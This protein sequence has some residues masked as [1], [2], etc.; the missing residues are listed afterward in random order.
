MLVE[1][2]N[3]QVRKPTLKQ[4][5]LVKRSVEIQAL[6]REI[7]EAQQR[8]QQEFNVGLAKNMELAYARI[9]KSVEAIGK[10]RDF[11]M[12]ID[13][14]PETVLF[15]KPTVDISDLIIAHLNATDAPPPPPTKPTP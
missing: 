2:L 13:R 8:I 5:E 11:D 9:Q 3:G 14:S 15:C 6:D 12:V 1:S 10:S 4:A 7:R